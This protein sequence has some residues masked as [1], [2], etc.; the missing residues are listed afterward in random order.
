M[1]RT[2]GQYLATNWSLVKLELVASENRFR[3]AETLKLPEDGQP[4][5]RHIDNLTWVDDRFWVLCEICSDEQLQLDRSGKV[6]G[7]FRLPYA[8]KAMAWD[9]QY[10]WASTGSV[11]KKL[12]LVEGSNELKE[13]DS[14][15][16]STGG[17]RADVSGLTWDRRNLWQVSSGV[18]SKLDSLAQ[19]ICSFSLSATA[20]TT[21]WRWGGM[22]WDGQFLWVVNGDANKLYRVDPN[23]CR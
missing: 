20:G 15:A 10:F 13:V 23:A 2:I 19:P 22:T 18:I 11:L 8:V 5:N 1:A 16:V 12:E 9:G 4:L 6:T 14:F 3:I 17:F 21:W 7:T